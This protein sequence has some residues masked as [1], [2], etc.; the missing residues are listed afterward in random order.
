MIEVKKGEEWLQCELKAYRPDL[1]NSYICYTVQDGSKAL[2]ATLHYACARPH[3]VTQEHVGHIIQVR[4]YWNK[5]WVMRELK[6]VKPDIESPPFL[7]LDAGENAKISHSASRWKYARVTPP[8][9]NAEHRHQYIK[10]RQSPDFP[11]HHR[12]L[13]E[14]RTGTERPYVC[15]VDGQ[16]NADDGFW[17]HAEAIEQP[18]KK[19]PQLPIDKIIMGHTSDPAYEPLVRNE[20]MEELRDRTIKV[21]LE[22]MP[23]KAGD[24]VEI[25]DGEHKGKFATFDRMADDLRWAD[26]CWVH[27]GHEE[28]KKRASL[29][30]PIS[31]IKLDQ[32]A[33]S[34]PLDAEPDFE[35]LTGLKVGDHVMTTAESTDT[36]Y[37]PKIKGGVTGVISKLSPPKGHQKTQNKDRPVAHIDWDGDTEMPKCVW[38]DHVE[39]IQK[40]R[41]KEPLYTKGQWVKI[42]DKD[43]TRFNYVCEVVDI[44]TTPD[45]KRLVKFDDAQLRWIPVKN[46]RY[47]TKE[48]REDWYRERKTSE[49]ESATP[50]P[51]KEESPDKVEMWAVFKCPDTKH[52][53]RERYEKQHQVG[54]CPYC[55][56]RRTSNYT[57]FRLTTGTKDKE[58]LLPLHN[59]YGP[60]IEVYT[61][62]G[63]TATA[64]HFLDGREITEVFWKHKVQERQHRRNFEDQQETIA[65][66]KKRL[67]KA[68]QQ[69]PEIIQVT[70]LG[71]GILHPIPEHH[72]NGIHPDFIPVMHKVPH[73]D[74]SEVIW[75]LPNG[76]L[77]RTDAPAKQ[78]SYDRHITTRPTLAS[79]TI[80]YTHYSAYLQF[81][82]LHRENGP[83]IVYWDKDKPDEPVFEQWFCQGKEIKPPES[84][85]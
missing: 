33:S 12:R 66:L 70:P 7:C 40:S 60:A 52:V 8:Q 73:V 82:R 69:F 6:T 54:V 83:A 81:D 48:E 16:D 21:D 63:Q 43:E 10:V 22:K 79:R 39:P 27:I 67:A 78:V 68:K 5:D 80:T 36:R 3:H 31:E 11:W 44:Q 46:L 49:K 20:V 30:L 25:I 72:D 50:E 56:Y 74:Y 42:S 85:T 13:I 65:D 51:A 1:E 62:T 29:F 17:R 84:Q 2:G 32:Q 19:F 77:H 57:E 15:V 24:I 4:N 38:A 34:S 41:K 61:T 75:K 64:Q 28:W 35:A 53:F 47:L 55:G 18:K 59:E 23:Y 58:G 26:R 76:M 14:I 45:H 71:D 37:A 9:V